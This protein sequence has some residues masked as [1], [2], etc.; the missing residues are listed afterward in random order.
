MASPCA[1]RQAAAPGCLRRIDP[2]QVK[3]NWH[4]VLRSDPWKTTPHTVLG[5]AGCRTRLRTTCMTAL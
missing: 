3:E 4:P 5:K 1:D 2:S